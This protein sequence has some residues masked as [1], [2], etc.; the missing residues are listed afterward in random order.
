MPIPLRGRPEARQPGVCLSSE[1][2]EI[3]SKLAACDGFSIHAIRKSDFIRKS[4]SARQLQLAE[5]EKA[6]MKL[7]QQECEVIKVEMKSNLNE[8]EA[9]NVQ[10]SLSM[11]EYTSKKN[12]RYLSMNTI[13]P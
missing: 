3:L 8:K 6:I 2:W 1:E 13:Q 10:F 11:D 12:R 7:I 4:L 9:T 5:S